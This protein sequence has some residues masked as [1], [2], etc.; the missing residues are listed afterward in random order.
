[1]SIKQDLHC[2]Y[3]Y[4]IRKKGTNQVET[5]ETFDKVFCSFFFLCKEMSPRVLKYKTCDDVT[6]FYWPNS[7]YLLGSVPITYNSKISNTI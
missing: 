7:F 5:K 3:I 4:I 1:M 6:T 2:V